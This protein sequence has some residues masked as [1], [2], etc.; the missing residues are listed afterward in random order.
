M[1][2]SLVENV[3][4]IDVVSV[5]SVKWLKKKMLNQNTILKPVMSLIKAKSPKALKIITD[6]YSNILLYLTTT[7][8]SGGH[9]WW[10]FSEE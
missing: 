5:L 6:I 10:I 8:Q 9:L 2:T 4:N 3:Q 7:H 1:C